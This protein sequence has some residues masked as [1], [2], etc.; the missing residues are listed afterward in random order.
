MYVLVS[1]LIII[2]GIRVILNYALSIDFGI[3]ETGV[4][5]MK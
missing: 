4:F 2:A 1:I 3:E 5:K